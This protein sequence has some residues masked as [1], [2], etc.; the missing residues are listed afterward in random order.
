M[1]TLRIFALNAGGT[2]GMTGKPLRPVKS[3][4]EILENI[5]LPDNI[6]LI[7][8]D[9][10]LRQDS[11]N[12]TIEDRIN[13]GRVIK[14]NYQNHE[15]FIVMHGT[16]TLVETAALFCMLFK[17]SLQKSLFIIG[18]QMAKDE[19][20][21]D[22]SIQLE[23]T[24]RAAKS[25][26]VWDIVGVYTICLGNILD[27][28]RLIKKSAFDLATFHAP[29]KMPAAK[30]GSD[31]L[32]NQG[33]SKFNLWKTKKGLLFDDNFAR[34][35]AII[36]VSADTPPWIMPK[37]TEDKGLD[38]V[39][40]ECKGAGNIPDK[41]WGCKQ[42]NYSWIDAIQMA[43]GQGLPVGIISPFEDGVMDLERYELGAEAKKAGAIA[44]SG[45]TPAM[46]EIKFRQAIAMFP[47]NP[48]LI[49]K[50]ISKN[51]VGELPYEF[52]RD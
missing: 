3:A 43:S 34:N 39:I 50:F 31:I 7:L 10:P 29:G 48:D 12:L 35:I 42:K 33:A 30:I 21:N 2:I 16:D 14:E 22:V 51:F 1:E 46:A 11:T 32:I 26:A 52:R 37:I 8:N 27:G 44:L 4:E 6:K 41:K 45:L 36:K 19:R 28:S 17:D 13:M 47:N 24:L 40:L 23:N 15:A 18:A 9:F 38:G 49:Q 5:R 25:F 20:G